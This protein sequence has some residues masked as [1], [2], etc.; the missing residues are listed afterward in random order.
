MIARLLKEVFGCFFNHHGAWGPVKEE[1][2]YKC[3]P[4]TGRKVPG[5]EFQR[6][7]QTR[8]CTECG[9]AERRWV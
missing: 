3:D 6:E 8:L 7:F 2:W 1:T 9:A 5:S 4:Y